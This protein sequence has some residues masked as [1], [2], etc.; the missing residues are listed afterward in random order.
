MIAMNDKPEWFRLVEADGIKP[1]HQVKWTLR[2]AALTAP[3][4]V[5][6]TGFVMAQTRGGHSPSASKVLAITSV[7]PV[8]VQSVQSTSEISPTP[9]P[10]ASETITPVNT[11]QSISLLATPKSSDKAESVA[12]VQVSVPSASAT[13]NPSQPATI[14]APLI[15]PPTGGGDD[16]GGDDGGGD[17]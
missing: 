15:K 14:I 6:G 7:Q 10:A 9:S 12:P 2:V 16:G 11:D 4:L 5:I 17:D 3:L 8:A 13:S 1:R